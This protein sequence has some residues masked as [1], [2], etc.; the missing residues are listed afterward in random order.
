[1]TEPNTSAQRVQ[2]QNP[3]DCRHSRAGF[4]C[5]FQS[6]ASR[7][8]L[9]SDAKLAHAALVSMVRRGLTWTQAEIAA[10]LGWESR[11]RVWRATSELVAAK[12]LA[13]RRVG[14]G[15]PNE[16]ILLPT[17]E[18]SPEDIKARAKPDRGNRAGHP[19]GRLPDTHARAVNS[20]KENRPRNRST[21]PST[22]GYLET[23]DHGSTDYL[24]T[25][26]GR[27]RVN[28]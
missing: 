10:E 6:V 5:S 23:R 2:S 13:V 20:P 17:D 21:P 4:H 26:Y 9:S 14:L 15:R 19:E 16:Y 24:A 27:L 11:Q 1:M 28:T 22:G 3:A 12:L 25:R 7:R 18:I 8:D